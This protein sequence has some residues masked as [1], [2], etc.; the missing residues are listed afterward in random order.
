MKVEAAKGNVSAR[1]INAK[2]RK[3]TE[4]KK[5]LAKMVLILLE[6]LRYVVSIVVGSR[7]R[8]DRL[9]PHPIR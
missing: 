3:R 7:R 6:F 2:A 4:A 1:E 9:R 5:L 8:W